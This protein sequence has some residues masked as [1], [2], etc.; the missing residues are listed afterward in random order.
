[1]NLSKTINKEIKLFFFYKLKNL[2]VYQ[3]YMHLKDTRNKH[4]IFHRYS[5]K[6]KNRRKINGPTEIWIWTE[7]L[8][9]LNSEVLTITPQN[10]WHESIISQ[11][12]IWFK[13]CHKKNIGKKNEG[14]F[15]WFFILNKIHRIHA[16]PEE[17]IISYQ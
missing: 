7:W 2:V 16:S 6:K 1:M 9:D 14:F 5:S 12:K 8:T 15:Q 13:K 11:S 4:N 17:I 10:R 3:I